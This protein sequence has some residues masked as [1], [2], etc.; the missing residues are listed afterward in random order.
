MLGLP[1]EHKMGIIA[2]MDRL[3]GLEYRVAFI[4]YSI[5]GKRAAEVRE[6]ANGATYISAEE[7]IEGTT[8]K[9]RHSGRM[10]GPF[11]SQWM[12]RNL[13]SRLSGSVVMTNNRSVLCRG[14]CLGPDYEN[15]ILILHLNTA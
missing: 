10:V 15:N 6:F 12:Q 5:D 8:F 1:S 4:L 14:T 11:A 9:N 3:T 7:W 13:L 2:N